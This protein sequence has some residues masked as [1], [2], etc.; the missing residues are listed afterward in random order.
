[1][2]DGKIKTLQNM[3]AGAVRRKEWR[4]KDIILAD[5]GKILGIVRF[6][7]A[8]LA[9]EFAFYQLDLNNADR[10]QDHYF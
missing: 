9:L 7:S 1:M 3:L 4:V 10:L 8:L 6:H 5:S 2:L